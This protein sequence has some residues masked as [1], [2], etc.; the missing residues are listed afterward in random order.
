M[1]AENVRNDEN[2]CSDKCDEDFIRCVE[3]SRTDCMDDFKDCSS[4]CHR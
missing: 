4:S 1:S 3:L 2:S